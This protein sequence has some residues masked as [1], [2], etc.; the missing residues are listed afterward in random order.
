MHS[1]YVRTHPYKLLTVLL[2]PSR[3]CTS[4]DITRHCYFSASKNTEL[5]K[6]AGRSLS[7]DLFSL[8]CSDS[9]C[10]LCTLAQASENLK[11]RSDA[12]LSDFSCTHENCKMVHNRLLFE[13]LIL[14]YG[15]DVKISMRKLLIEK[16][17]K[18]ALVEQFLTEHL[19]IVTLV[20]S[21]WL[22]RHRISQFGKCGFNCLICKWSLSTLYFEG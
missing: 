7:K 20:M 10:P 22:C 17:N 14:S 3:R 2:I 6:K 5:P 16:D 1:S 11:H 8:L 12:V 21:L 18:L 15:K 19:L 13:S 9:A 4:P